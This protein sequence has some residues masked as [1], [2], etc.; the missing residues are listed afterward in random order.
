MYKIIPMGVEKSFLVSEDSIDTPL[1]G[2]TSTL[3]DY[4]LAWA[5][6]GALGCNLVKYNNV[7]ENDKLSFYLDIVDRE[8]RYKLV[9]IRD[10]VNRVGVLQSIDYLFITDQSLNVFADKIRAIKNVAYICDMSILRHDDKKLWS[11]IE[12][13][14]MRI[15]F[16]E[17]D[18]L[19]KQY[20]PRYRQK[21]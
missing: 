15:E 10:I 16:H 20:P 9:S 17:M 5:I 7:L 12:D 18:V 19:G 4:K 3:A 14:L 13:I 1:F 21:Q 11:A 6:N 8:V 2:I